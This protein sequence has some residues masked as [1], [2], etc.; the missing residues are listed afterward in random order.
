M[1]MYA[2]QREVRAAEGDKSPVRQLSVSLMQ[3]NDMMRKTE[4]GERFVAC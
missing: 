4:L 1:G 2:R 3:A